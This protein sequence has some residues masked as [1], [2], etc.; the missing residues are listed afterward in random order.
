VPWYNTDPDG[1]LV[2]EP[3]QVSGKPEA[4]GK[5]RQNEGAALSGKSQKRQKK[6]EVVDLANSFEFGFDEDDDD[7][8]GRE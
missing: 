1:I 3:A 5:K 7:Y 2:E 4:G 6:P 8:L